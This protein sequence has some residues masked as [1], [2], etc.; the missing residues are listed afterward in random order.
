MP[1]VGQSYLDARR[2]QIVDAART[3]FTSDGFADAPGYRT[4]STI[5]AGV[6]AQVGKEAAL[7]PALE[8]VETIEKLPRQHVFILKKK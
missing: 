8:W 3:R 5:R 1:K 4:V 6:L 7:I 2:K